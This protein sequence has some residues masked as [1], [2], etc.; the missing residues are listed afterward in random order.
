MKRRARNWDAGKAAVETKETQYT[1]LSKKCSLRPG[2]RLNATWASEMPLN[3]EN[4]PL[5]RRYSFRNPA[6][7]N[8]NK[9]EENETSRYAGTPSKPAS[10]AFEL[11]D[12]LLNENLFKILIKSYEDKKEIRK[13]NTTDAGHLR[14]FLRLRP[15]VSVSSVV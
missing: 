3:D 15:C 8:R 4:G 14:D 9:E 10:K 2:P 13:R 6:A 1:V 7:V 5:D 12:V 11:R